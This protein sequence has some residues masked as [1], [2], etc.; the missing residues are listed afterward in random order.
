MTIRFVIIHIIKTNNET[1]T[2]RDEYNRKQT[3][4]IIITNDIKSD[5]GIKH[6]E[7]VSTRVNV[8]YI[9]IVKVMLITKCF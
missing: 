4:P 5:L 1:I 8:I 6:T 7:A 3:N 2:I 9:I